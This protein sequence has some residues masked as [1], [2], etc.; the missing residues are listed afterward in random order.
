[1]DYCVVCKNDVTEA[2]YLLIGTN[3]Y[4][5][6]PGCSKNAGE[7]VFYDCPSAFG[8]TVKRIT[9]N[10]PMG[11]QSHC[12][13]CRA[14]KV[15]PY[16]DGL[17]C[18]GIE[19]KDGVII[20]EIRFL[21][22]STNVFPTYDE[23]RDFL[24]YD[25]LERGN[26]YYYM[27]SKMDCINN[28]FVLFQYEARLIGYAIFEEAFTLDEPLYENGSEYHG[29]YKFRKNSTKVLT[30]PITAEMFKM[31]DVE[32]KG[33]NQSHQRKPVGML[34]AIFELINTG[35]GIVQEIKATINLPEEIDE[36]EL[37]NLKEGQKKQ[38]VV[39]AYERNQQARRRCLEYYSKL[40]NG[41][42]KCE[43]CGFDFGEVYGKEF[44]GKIHIHHI[45]EISMISEEYVIDATKDLIPI[46]PN[47]HM[48]A[49]SRKPALKP[50]EICNLVNN[51][52]YRKR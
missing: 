36:A 7:H 4:K 32:F 19:K 23:A 15:G 42:I 38:I 37:E 45:K 34:P 44:E 6:C 20:N 3:V 35:K 51:N 25:M 29:Y 14:N 11:L 52:K 28:S 17:L 39:N 8:R 31:I 12:G 46:C 43:I 21:P 13:R 22:M 1:M 18:S 24:L 47:C 50:D 27:K 48:V 2:E 5:S 10:N 49:H 30:T 41:K 26:T 33:F 16:D 40:N 9:R